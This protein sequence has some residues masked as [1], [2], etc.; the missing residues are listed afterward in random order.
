MYQRNAHSLYLH[1]FIFNKYKPTKGQTN[2]LWKTHKIQFPI[3]QCYTTSSH[4]KFVAN[5]LLFYW[6]IPVPGWIFFSGSYHKS[7]PHFLIL[8]LFSD[9]ALSI[10][11]TGTEYY[12]LLCSSFFSKNF[13]IN[14]TAAF[15]SILLKIFITILC[16]LLQFL[17]V[18]KLNVST[19][20]KYTS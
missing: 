4:F 8:K 9:S 12:S 5:P 1:N 2:V 19:I 10:I 14:I 17:P 13:V 16:I 3:S 15:A 11:S 18:S 6:G 7:L 20:L